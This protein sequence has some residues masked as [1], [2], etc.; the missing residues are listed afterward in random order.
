METRSYVIGLLTLGVVLLT[1]LPVFGQEGGEQANKGTST[2][3][4]KFETMN[5]SQGLMDDFY[6]SLNEQLNAQE[7]MHVVS[8]GE[9]TIEELILTVGCDKPDPS[10]LSGLSDFVDAERMVFGSVQRSEDVYLFSVKMFDF[11]EERFVRKVEEQTLQGDEA[12]VKAAIPSIVEGFLHGDVG[13]LKVSAKGA[14]EGRVFFDGQKMGLAPTTLENLPLGQHA[15]TI[16]TADGEEKTEFVVLRKGETAEVAFDFGGGSTGPVASGSAG[17]K[18][19]IAGFAAAGAG[20]VGVA[21]G[22]VGQAQ[23]S[24]YSKQADNLLCGSGDATICSPPGESLSPD[25]MGAR[26][27]EVDQKLSSSATMSVV[28]YSAGAVGLGVGG[29]LLFRHYASNPEGK[30]PAAEVIRVSPKKGGVQVGVSLD[31]K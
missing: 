7:E 10:C 28:G 21:V 29:Y 27:A 6:V 23:N 25:E 17:E 11:A 22:I 14:G 2:V 4:L 9:V 8:G 16:K 13:T 3:I 1:G 15:V 18:P 24:K 12:A 26:A 19:P 31:F 5:V 20:L 30:Q